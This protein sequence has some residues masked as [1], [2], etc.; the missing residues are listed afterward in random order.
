MALNI[1]LHAN[2]PYGMDRPNAAIGYL[3]SFLSEEK[4]V[5]VTNIYWNLPPKELF[6]T[7]SSIPT[8]LDRSF[9]K[10]DKGQNFRLI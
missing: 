5:N 7:V 2:F 4:H 6:E 9:D 1:H 8:K 3:K 10:H